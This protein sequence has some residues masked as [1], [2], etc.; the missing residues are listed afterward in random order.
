M[1]K[2]INNKIKHNIKLIH[3]SVM[4][5]LLNYTSNCENN[6]DNDLIVSNVY[7]EFEKEII[8]WLNDNYENRTQF[9]PYGE[10]LINKYLANNLD[11]YSSSRKIR[12]Y[13]KYISK[14]IDNLVDNQLI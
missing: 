9:G 7:D 13:R 8:L 3:K 4:L 6:T 11:K 10:Y 12:K 2:K 14:I 1:N 5:D